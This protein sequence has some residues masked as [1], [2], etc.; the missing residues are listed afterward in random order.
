VKPWVD[1]Q[2]CKEEKEKG[3]KGVRKKGRKGAYFLKI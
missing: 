1:A 3:R 2:Y